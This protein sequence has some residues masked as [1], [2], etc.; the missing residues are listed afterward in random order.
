VEEPGSRTGRPSGSRLEWVNRQASLIDLA[1]VGPTVGGLAGPAGGFGGHHRHPGAVDGDVELVGQRRRREGDDPAGQDRA[2]VGLGGR[3]GGRTVGLG[4]AFDPLGGQRDP[5]QVAQQ[6]AGLGEP[7]GGARAVHH[8]GQPRRQRRAGHAQLVVPGHHAVPAVGAVVVGAAHLDRAEH[9]VDGLVPVADEAGLVA[10]PAVGARA[11]V[12]GIGGQ[13]PF[14]QRTT[15]SQHRGADRQL[16]RRQALPGAQRPRGQR[17]PALYLG[18]ELGLEPGAEPPFSPSA[19]SR[20]EPPPA[21][22]AETGLAS[23]IASLTS[24]ICSDSA[25]NRW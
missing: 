6:A 7:G 13:Q 15:Q 18:G 5:G 24:T 12:A 3:R 19:S 20:A 1:G 11:A 21:A 23:Q 2:G 10:G 16:H 9:G 4:G 25:P 8:R 14:Q 22:G 17:R